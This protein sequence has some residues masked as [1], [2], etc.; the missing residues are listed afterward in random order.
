[1]SINTTRHP[2]S[3]TS[4]VR[5]R[6]SAR[7]AFLAPATHQ[8]GAARRGNPRGTVPLSLSH[9]IASG[10]I[11]CAKSIPL[12]RLTPSYLSSR[13]SSSQPTDRLSRP[14][15]KRPVDFPATHSG[16]APPNCGDPG[17][18]HQTAACQPLALHLHIDVA[19]AARPGEARASPQ[20]FTGELELRRFG[21]IFSEYAGLCG[22]FHSAT[23]RPGQRHCS[24]CKADAADPTDL[25]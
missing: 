20:V 19:P 24:Q 5:H 2:L 3:P 18:E 6:Q 1:M 22:G 23:P 12:P 25:L 16:L 13:P 8:P 15:R 11:L 17:R 21:D 7:Q 14:D 4:P 10:R 9:P